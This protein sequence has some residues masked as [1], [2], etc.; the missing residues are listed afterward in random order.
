VH[1]F[2][3]NIGKTTCGK[4]LETCPGDRTWGVRRRH[5]LQGMPAHDR[6]AKGTVMRMVRVDRALDALNIAKRQAFEEAEIT[7]SEEIVRARIAT[8]RGLAEA[9]VSRDGEIRRLE[10]DRD[11]SVELAEIQS[12]IEIARATAERSSAIAASEGARAKAIEAEEQAITAREREIAERRKV[13]E[14][15]AAANLSRQFP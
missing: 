1:R 3:A 4:K 9:R 14:L 7:S 11:R 13:T 15:I 6:A 2:E 12:A 5:Q 8:E 10:V